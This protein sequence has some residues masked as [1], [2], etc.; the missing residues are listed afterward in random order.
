MK[1]TDQGIVFDIFVQPRASRNAVAGRHGDALKIRITAP[2]VDDKANKMVVQYLAKSLGLPRSTVK[3]VSGHTGRR[4]QVLARWPD[5]G[6]D[7]A[8]R[9]ALKNRIGDLF[10]DE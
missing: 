3:I 7:P 5:D 4:K 8:A 1:E 10:G 6:H 9:T 2:P